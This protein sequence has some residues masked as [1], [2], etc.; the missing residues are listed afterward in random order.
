MSVLDELG[1]KHNTDK[2][3]LDRMREPSADLSKRP[4]GH[5]YLI[6]YEHFLRHLTHKSNITILELGAGPDWNIGASAYM[7]ADYFPACN[8]IHI[9]EIRPSS[10]KIKTDRIHPRIGDLSNPRFLEELGETQ[11]DFIIDDASHVWEHQK[12]ALATLISSVKNGGIYVIEDIHTS[13]GKFRG[14]YCSSSI[15]IKRK[16]A[17]LAKNK[18]S[19]Y[20]KFM[21]KN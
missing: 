16:N 11:W 7:W 5:N 13:F 2:A 20:K 21:Q 19:W 8:Q 9:A 10:K 6:K 17:R 14:R 4:P 15:A 18:S 3:S 1:I 12:L